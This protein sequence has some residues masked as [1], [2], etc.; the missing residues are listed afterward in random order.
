[1]VIEGV[2]SVLSTL[3]HNNVLLSRWGPSRAGS[4][5]AH[6]QV[7]QC[8]IGSRVNILFGDSAG[9]KEVFIGYYG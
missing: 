6:E 5:S 1:V 7:L 8:V 2:L 3:E 9:D 4:R